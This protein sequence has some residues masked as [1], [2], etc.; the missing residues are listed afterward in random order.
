MKCNLL[1]NLLYDKLTSYITKNN[2][3]FLL[4]LSGGLD[5]VVLLYLLIEFKKVFDL[6]IHLMHFNYNTNSNSNKA[7]MYCLELSK[8]F[9]LNLS[10]KSI[11][12]SNKN[13]ESKARE[14]RYIL[15]E[16]YAEKYNIGTI[17][18]AH[19]YDDQ[20]E[21]L[22]MN[23]LK[24]TDW[25]SMVGIHPEKDKIRR[26]L[27]HLKKRDLCNYARL[28]NIK[29]IEDLT[30]KN[31]IFF[32]NN[33][34]NN[35]I[36]NILSNKPK[37]INKLLLQSKNNLSRYSDL[38]K[39]IKHN[40]FSY[41]INFDN[42]HML[43]HN[44]IVS[45][46]SSIEMKLIYQI[47]LKK[48]FNYKITNSNKHWKNFH[49]FINCS[50]PGSKFFINDDVICIMD[51][52]SHF[53][54]FKDYYDRLLN[55]KYNKK[56][57]INK[58]PFT[59]NRSSTIFPDG[60]NYNIMIPKKNLEEGLYVRYWRNGDE[61]YSKY[62]DKYIK[63]KKIFINNKLSIY[64]KLITPIFLDK[65]DNIISIP[66]VYNRNNDADLKLNWKIK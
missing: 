13:F 30:N 66:N 22:Y 40:L 36:P 60:R 41:L 48:K 38:L 24:K 20:I 3:R 14:S 23:Y 64:H 28:N 63:V 34:R 46:Y 57:K 42:N 17:L 26:P 52:K 33:V 51:R 44:N 59:W 29:W 9:N 1:N 39:D 27:L 7:Q 55:L 5:S 32:R 12:L 50:K 65:S 11:N 18:T 37:L 19:H 54:F 56:V 62:Y 45:N 35:L 49:N 2:K 16:K 6:D 4:S 43:I 8:L 47:L 61:C 25:I 58:F 15:L 31:N 21:T 53:I 10:I